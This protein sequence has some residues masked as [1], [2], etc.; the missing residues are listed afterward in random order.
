MKFSSTKS[1]AAS[2]W[3]RYERDALG[4]KMLNSLKH[5]DWLKLRNDFINKYMKDFRYNYD[6]K[7]WFDLNKPDDESNMHRHPRNYE[8]R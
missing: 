4:V 5:K 3:G 7:L 6:T 8:V 2:A 1:G